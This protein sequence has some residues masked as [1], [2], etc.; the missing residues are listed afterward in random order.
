MKK[1]I[2]TVAAIRALRSEVNLPPKEE[3]DVHLFLDD[4]DLREYFKNSEASF[5]ELARL[6]KL[7]LKSKNSDRPKK[8]AIN[9]TTFAEIFLPLEGHID[10]GEQVR[11]LK[12]DLEKTQADFE[13]VKAKL[14]NSKFM[15]SAPAEV[16][17][18]VK[19]K[20]QDFKSKIESLR[21]NLGFFDA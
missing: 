11:R 18:E 4:E 20:S 7:H 2:E 15:E 9:A 13:K 16:I 14:D 12:K 8:S 1:F 10:I 3:V 17:E 6:N 19:A 5:K 21:R